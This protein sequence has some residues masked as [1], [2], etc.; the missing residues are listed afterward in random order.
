MRSIFYTG[1]C[2]SAFYSTIDKNYS[3]LNP[4]IKFASERFS[5]RGC[6]EMTV[7]RDSKRTVKF[8]SITSLCSPLLLPAS[9][10][11]A[12][13]P[14]S[15]SPTLYT[16]KQLDDYSEQRTNKIFHARISGTQ[17]NLIM[18]DFLCQATRS[19]AS[20]FMFNHNFLFSLIPFMSLIH[21]LK[22]KIFSSM[23]WAERI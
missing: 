3:K 23:A 5:V 22:Q 16:K 2:Y 1:A 7:Y 17:N 4:N 18:N 20:N 13:H 14:V 12:P 8:P 21:T 11:P 15:P 10:C 9:N 6:L 19:K